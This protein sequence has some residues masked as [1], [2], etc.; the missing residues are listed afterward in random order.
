M[1]VGMGVFPPEAILPGEAVQV[2]VKFGA[3]GASG[4]PIVTEVVAQLRVEGRPALAA[5]GKLSATTTIDA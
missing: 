2:Y 5:G 3:M 4:S 1:T